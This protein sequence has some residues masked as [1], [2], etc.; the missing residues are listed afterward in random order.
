MSKSY[1]VLYAYESKEEGNDIYIGYTTSDVNKHFLNNF[2]GNA[3]V[4]KNIFVRGA[5]N[6]TGSV[7]TDDMVKSYFTHHGQV[8]DKNGCFKISKGELLLAIDNLM[9]G[10]SLQEKAHNFGLRPEQLEAVSMTKEYYE[11]M[12]KTDPD[13]IPHFLWNCKMRFG[14]TFAAYQLAKTMKWKRILILTFKPAV[15]SA[16]EDDILTHVDFEGWKFV[17]CRSTTKEPL[18]SKDVPLVCFGSFQDLMGKSNSGGIKVKNE[19]IHSIN[20]D[21]VIFDE[22]HYGAWRDGAQ[23]LFESESNEFSSQGLDYFD[24]DLMPITTR[25]YLY[26]SGTPFRAI[27]T[28]EFIEQQIYNWTYSDE[29]KAKMNWN[30][31]LIK[32][33]YLSLPRVIM[34]TYKLPEEIRVISEDEYGFFDLNEFFSTIGNGKDASFVNKE[35]VQE[36][37]NFICGNYRGGIYDDVKSMYG[38]KLT[39]PFSNENLIDTLRHTFWFLPKVDSCYAMKNLLLEPQNKFFSDYNI[40]VA[41]GNEAGMGVNALLPVREAMASPDPLSTKSITLSCGKL[42]T[43]VTVKPWTGIFILRNL[44]SPETYFQAAFRVQSPWTIKNS[45]MFSNGCDEILKDD[46]YIFDF[47]PNRALKQIADYSCRLSLDEDNPETKVQDFIRYMPILAFEDG[48]LFE[49]HAESILDVSLSGTS[50]SLLARRWESARLVN[51]DDNTLQRLLDNPDAMAA[52]MKLEGFRNLNAD[53]ESIIKKGKT[54][55]KKKK[56]GGKKTKQDTEEEREYKS[57]RKELQEKLIRF[58]ARI[59]IFMYL[60]DYREKCLKDIIM[61]LEPGLFK[62]VTGLEI[63]DFDLLLSLGVFNGQ[64]MNDA[65]YK[66]KQYE[67]SSLDYAGICKHDEKFI[68]GFDTVITRKEYNLL[69]NIPNPP[70]DLSRERREP[71][72][73]ERLELYEQIFPRTGLNNGLNLSDDFYFK[74]AEEMGIEDI[75]CITYNPRIDENRELSQD[76]PKANDEACDN[77]YSA[78]YSPAEVKRKSNML[79]QVFFHLPEEEEK[80]KALAKEAQADAVRRYYTPLQCKLKKG[81]KVDISLNIYGEKLLQSDKEQVVWSGSITNCTF[82]YYVPKDIEDE[83][84][85]CEVFLSV[86]GAPIGKITFV[87]NI[88]E[89]P[90]SLHPEIFSRSF[91]K[92][93]I[94]YA[95]QDEDIARPYAQAYKYQG[96]D[97]F[98]DRDYLKA[99]DIFPQKIKD[100][101]NSAD[102]FMLFWSKNA[103][104]SD[105]VRKERDMALE[106]AYPKVKPIEKAP[107][108][109]CPLSIEPRAELPENMRDVYNFEQI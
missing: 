72:E 18:I 98:F 40:V 107:L 92:I 20:W 43:G 86:N 78:I 80:V 70:K 11:Y 65:I 38:Q 74:A 63:E 21:C 81:D 105:Y 102:L 60:T 1:P 44:N 26:L 64:L 56:E 68:G 39:A 33:P 15:E 23:E 46:C 37:L 29:Q 7:V 5:M 53:L 50:A 54:I 8:M 82:F 24:E 71:Q 66:F 77:V 35:F 32:N 30:N 55:K 88:V 6:S 59:P 79:I 12:S 93:F 99:G 22:Y 57:L 104:K 25:H 106:R 95:H 51:V 67:D 75:D 4:F 62:K 41:A 3:S 101:I 89:A 45:E 85:R 61:K 103:A 48:K 84:L 73:K 69:N 58:A 16:W 52:L 94:S 14:K 19:W 87:T 97:Y 13:K 100:Y 31:P 90:R 91:K 108:S 42:T 96:V 27:S 109:I 34:L 17:S 28:G 49:M 76:Y 83:Q 10:S 2:P 9:K 47:S 36:W